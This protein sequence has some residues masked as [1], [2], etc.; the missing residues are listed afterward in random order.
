M[1]VIPRRLHQIWV[2]ERDMPPECARWC[3]AWRDLCARAGWDYR[4]WRDNDVLS[5]GFELFGAAQ[6]GLVADV[7]RYQILFREGG[8]YLDVD[9]EPLAFFG[10]LLGDGARLV[11][12]R[13][14]DI[15]LGTAF[16]ACEPRHPALARVLARVPGDIL[17]KASI[18]ARTGP[19]IFTRALMGAVPEERVKLVARDVFYSLPMVEAAHFVPPRF[20]CGVHRR[21]ELWRSPS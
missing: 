17:G 20:A 6:P 1:S 7:A 14:T 12:A 10:H 2:G 15:Y 18:W 4:L 21:F 3:G 11:A 5:A 16:I 19:R 9:V 13:E 8:V